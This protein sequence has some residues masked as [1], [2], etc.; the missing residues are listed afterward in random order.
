[1]GKIF[2]EHI[3]DGKPCLEDIKNSLQINKKGTNYFFKRAKYFNRCITKK[4]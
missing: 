2:A 3:S 4:I 1:M